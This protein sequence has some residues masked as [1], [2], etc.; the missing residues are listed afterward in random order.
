MHRY[1]IDH[2]EF[3]EYTLDVPLDWSS[4]NNSP[5]IKLFVREVV[6]S[7]QA[8]VELP[9]LLFLQGGP[10]GKGPRPQGNNPCWLE[11]AL[12]HYRVIFIDQ[13]GTGR[14]GRIDGALMASMTAEQG[15]D[16]LLKFRADSI[17]KDCEYLR[18]Q[19]FNGQ[20]FY[21][22][23]QSYGG[24]ITLSYLSYAPQGLAGC[25]ITGGL[26]AIDSPIDTLYQHTYQLVT[27]KTEQ[28]YQRYPQDAAHLAKIADA[29]SEQTVYLPN[30][31]LFSSERLQSLGI[32][33]GTGGGFDRFHYLIEEAF[34]PHSSE[35]LSDSFLMEILSLSNY[36][37]NPLY[38]AVHESIY[39]QG[40]QATNWSAQRLREQSGAFSP[41]LRPFP[42]T[43]EMIY[44]WMFSEIQAL[45]PFASA[46]ASLAQ[47][48]DYP[49]LYDLFQLQSN[50][51]PIVAA[52][53]AHD[54]YVPK[55]LSLHTA[56]LVSNTHP[57][58]CDEFEH[59]GLRQSASVFA[60]LDTML[61][62]LQY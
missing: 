40:T 46:A 53:Y 36:A 55:V 30:G 58:I 21:T 33:F 31:D 24:F 13:R 3:N 1:Q 32:L 44:P 48:N 22:L 23:G 56:E 51:V 25:Y 17:V 35:Q 43:G 60:H 14:S 6:L 12:Q 11:Q 47:Y 28:Y 2:L 50:E 5:S 4:V 42:L 16:Y 57:W 15:R 27:Q 61:V 20:R 62:Q 52:V 8:R 19:R 10:G 18:K 45:Q 41:D 39:G 49:S 59:D 37:D 7:E 9:L 54:M 34:A 38:A 26:A 29:L